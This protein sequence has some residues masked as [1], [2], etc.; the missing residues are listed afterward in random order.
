MRRRTALATI[1]ASAV[2][3]AVASGTAAAATRPDFE[4]LTRNTSFEPAGSTRAEATR[5]D[6]SR[7]NGAVQAFGAITYPET[8]E[9]TVEFVGFDSTPSDVDVALY[10]FT[11]GPTTSTDNQTVSV[12]GD[13]QYSSAEELDDFFVDMVGDTLID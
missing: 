9:T 1:G 7:L 4:G 3:L 8:A 12:R 10:E 11:R 5:V 2:G 13:F 6:T